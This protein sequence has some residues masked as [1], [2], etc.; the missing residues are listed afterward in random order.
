V[1]TFWSIWRRSICAASGAMAGGIAG[2]LFGFA[3]LGRQRIPLQ[4]A[5]AINT[6]LL[7]G[8]VGWLA[9][10]V[11]VGLWL[12]YGIRTIALPSLFTSLLTGILTVLIALHV[13]LAFL[14]VWIGLL[15]GT[16]VGAGLC[17]LCGWRSVTRGESNA[18]R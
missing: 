6:G 17:R 9:V 13:W 12:H 18:L 1:G 14:D 8:G 2:M 11:V 15:V 7:L 3:Q 16:I 4:T 5:A 10:L